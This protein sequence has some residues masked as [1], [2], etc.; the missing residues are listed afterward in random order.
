MLV[1]GSYLGHII[2]LLQKQNLDTLILKEK[3][4]KEELFLKHQEINQYK[5]SK[6]GGNPNE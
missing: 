2:N 4:L 3:E 5:V 6:K 1:F